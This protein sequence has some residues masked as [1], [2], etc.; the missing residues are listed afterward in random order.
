MMRTYLR[1]LRYLRPYGL[2]LTGSLVCILL[3][4]LLSSASLFSIL[5]FLDVVFYGVDKS[6][7]SRAAPAET[8]SMPA[9]PTT[10]AV[11]RQQIMQRFYALLLGQDRRST[12]LRL[13]GLILLLIFSKNLFDYLQAYFMAHVEQGVIMDLRNDLYRHLHRLSLGYFN[14]NRTGNL[15]SRITNDVT[16][17]NNGLSAS[18]VTLVKNPL[19][20]AAYLGMAFLLSWKLTLV[21]LLIVPLSLAVIGSLASRLR[22]ASHLSQAKMADLTSV[23]QETISGVR[24]VKAFAMEDFEVR[25]FM[26]ES[27]SYFKTLLRV[28]RISRLAAPITESLGAA[29]G[30]GIL[31][32]G[33]QQVLAG[34]SLSSSEFLLFL[35]AIFSLMQPVKELSTV[36]SRLQEAMA[37]GERIFRVLDTAPEVVSLPGARQLERFEHDIRYE[38]VSFAY[39]QTAVLQ[40]I[41]FEVRKGEILAIVGPSGA[42]KSTLVDLLPRFYDPSGGRILIDGIDLREVE[43]Q[44]LRRLMGIVTQ[45]TI[46]F[47]GTVR[48]NIAYGLSDVPE[49]RLRA[50]AMAANAHRFIM[51][52]PQGYDTMIGERGLKLSGGQRQRLAIA[53]ALLKN[54]PILIL[55]EATSA[56]DSESELLVQ[57]A[58]ER[59]MANRT[60]FVIA[61]RLSTILH[62][63]RIIVLEGGRLVQVGTHEELLQQSGIY[64]KLYRM[65]FRA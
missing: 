60:S 6:G 48:S 21:A 34:G 33:G 19:L 57:Q 16:L 44:S 53:R 36:G 62:A 64:Q 40:D 7:V 14:Q 25:N 9:A 58:I 4:T 24:V 10:L 56:L 1:I 32:F 37:A 2:A 30:V 65:Q 61:H 22:R 15:M 41:S 18:F 43:L 29:V 11:A 49:D 3:F 17:V 26:R 23:L 35:L 52:L 51:E 38:N 45:E 46:L 42:G 59:L 12:L 28:T 27:R 8:G 5:P 13:C 50:A 47:H 39:E 31:W 20:I 55:D 54:P 63:H